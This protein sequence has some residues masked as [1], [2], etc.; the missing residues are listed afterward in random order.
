MRQ[1]LPPITIVTHNGSNKE[2]IFRT[3]L[4]GISID[5]RDP[6]FDEER[7]QRM[8]PHTE[9]RPVY[10][11]EEKAREDAAWVS[12]ACG[13]ATA[14]TEDARVIPEGK[15]R[16]YLYADTV[17]FVHEPNGS[18][19]ILEKPHQEPVDWATNSPEAMAQSG[20]DVE[21]VNALTAIRCGGDGRVSDPKTVIVRVHAH[22][23]P[24]TRA[25]VIAYA[26][27]SGNHTM[28]NDAGGISLAN[29]GRHFYDTD[30]PLIVTVQDSID[31]NESELF[32]F[33][34]WALVPDRV[35]RPFICGAIEPAVIRLVDKTGTPPVI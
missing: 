11:S 21:I 16:I 20:K 5:G 7:I 31:A 19:T 30:K 35:L 17:Q 10:I 33:D 13:T 23:R 28:P 14:F 1:E 26:K 32:R 24:Y 15:D 29:G 25:D 9:R 6:R 4:P 8:A 34:T 3:A 27:G 12:A 2:A 22:M 18:L